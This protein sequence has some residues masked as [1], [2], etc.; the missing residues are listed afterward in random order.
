[1]SKNP[2]SVPPSL[3]GGG[4]KRNLGVDDVDLSSINMYVKSEKQ[5]K[6]SAK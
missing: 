4:S 6:V 1:M 3:N 2:L 5:I